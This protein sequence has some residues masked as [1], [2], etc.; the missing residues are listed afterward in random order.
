[1]CDALKSLAPQVP[2]VDAKIGLGI[3]TVKIM[4]TRQNLHKDEELQVRGRFHSPYA[5]LLVTFLAL[6]TMI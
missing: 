5:C 4:G 1:V 6:K 2:S 3:R